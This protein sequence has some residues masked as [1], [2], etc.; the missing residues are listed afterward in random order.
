MMNL[1]ANMDLT[2]LMD[3]IS[4]KAIDGIESIYPP[5][6]DGGNSNGGIL[7]NFNRNADFAHS[8]RWM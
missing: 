1:L 5:S 4:A 6:K 3:N 2:N 8:K 7:I